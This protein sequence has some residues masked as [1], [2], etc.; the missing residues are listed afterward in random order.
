MVEPRAR[1]YKIGASEIAAVMGWDP[2]RTTFQLWLEKMGLVEPQKETYRMRRG[3][4]LERL[5]IEREYPEITGREVKYSDQSEED[6][7]RPYMICTPDGKCLKEK[8]GVEA[9]VVAYDQRRMWDEGPPPHVFLQCAWSMYFFDYP[10]W[11]VISVIGDGEPAVDTLER[12]LELE[13]VIANR[14]VEFYSLHL[15]PEVQPPIDGSA[16][17]AIYLQRKFPRHARPDVRPATAEEIGVLEE[18]ARVRGTYMEA[19]A[20]RSY[21]EN[22]LRNA[23]GNNEGIAWEAGKFLWRKTRDGHWM[24]WQSMAIALLYKFIRDEG[25]RKALEESYKRPKPGIRRI[26][27]DHK[28]TAAGQEEEEAVA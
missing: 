27:F 8:R 20:R 2:R 24:D 25:E 6:P 21:L 9:K 17:T 15:L 11:D 1:R 13:A 23:V 22:V 26:T 14:A 18:Y 10:R 16:A 4:I 5:L 3:K 19:K 12:D 7:E 28:V